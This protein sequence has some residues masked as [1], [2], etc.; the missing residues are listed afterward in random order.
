MTGAVGSL[1]DENGDEILTAV[2]LT[3]NLSSASLTFPVYPGTPKH[4][5]LKV[6]LSLNFSGVLFEDT[7]L[8]GAKLRGITIDSKNLSR[9]PPD[10]LEQYRNTFRVIVIK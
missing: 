6:C 2:M 8:S 3:G 10:L 9:I 4:N 7:K 5:L 1:T